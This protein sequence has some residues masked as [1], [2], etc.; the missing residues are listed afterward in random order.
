MNIAKM[1]KPSSKPPQVRGTSLGQSIHFALKRAYGHSLHGAF[2]SF[3]PSLKSSHPPIS[4]FVFLCHF[5]IQIEKIRD[6]FGFG[7]VWGEAVGGEN[8]AIV[9]LVRGAEARS[10]CRDRL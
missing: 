5:R 2:A 9:G 3:Q 6:D 1:A 8:G 7:R 10:Q 4:S